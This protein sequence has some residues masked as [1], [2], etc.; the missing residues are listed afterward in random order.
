MRYKYFITKC[1]LVKCG[2]GDQVQNRHIG[3]HLRKFNKGNYTSEGPVW[4]LSSS[5]SSN[6]K[7]AQSQQDPYI[8]VIKGI[9]LRTFS[10]TEPS[11]KRPQNMSMILFPLLCVESESQ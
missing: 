11:D 4:E 3:D 2:H 1:L 8:Q 5:G 10:N 9:P 7:N 6:Q